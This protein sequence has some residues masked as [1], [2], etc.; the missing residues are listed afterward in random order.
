MP[1]KAAAR[2]RAAFDCDWADGAL[3]QMVRSVGPWSFGVPAEA[4]IQAAYVD[5][6]RGARRFVYI[7]NQFFVTA[8]AP[9][10]PSGVCNLIA[11][12]IVARVKRA[13]EDG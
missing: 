3:V 9:G 13:H 7:E 10:M 11:E 2:E 4:S 1:S 6:I 12:A 8:T 5:A